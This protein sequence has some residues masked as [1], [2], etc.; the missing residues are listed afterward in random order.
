MH[1][2]ALHKTAYNRAKTARVG[3]FAQLD[4][5]GGGTPNSG[6]AG[7]AFYAALTGILEATCR[8]P[9]ATSRLGCFCL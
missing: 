8:A 9:C 6:R 2:T 5:G 7:S 3:A 4:G 1:M